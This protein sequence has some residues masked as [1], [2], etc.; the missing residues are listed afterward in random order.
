MTHHPT[1]MAPPV[2]VLAMQSH[3]AGLVL[4]ITFKL[5]DSRGGGSEGPPRAPDGAVR[6]PDGAVR[7]CVSE[8]IVFTLPP[9]R[10]RFLS[11]I[12]GHGAAHAQC[13]LYTR[14]YLDCRMQR[15]V[16]GAWSHAARAWAS[17]RPLSA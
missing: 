16:L 13:K 4:G 17:G 6:A 10:Q 2:P 1:A 9:V 5:P 11:C 12:R 8:G 15:F 7:A 14:E 3:A